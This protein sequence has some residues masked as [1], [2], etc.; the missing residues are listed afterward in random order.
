MF[1]TMQFHADAKKRR[2]FFTML[3]ATGELRRYKPN[4]DLCRIKL[5]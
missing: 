1:L 2:S 5:K 4:D 3:S